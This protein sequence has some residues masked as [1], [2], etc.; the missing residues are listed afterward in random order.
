MTEL[1]AAQ[2]FAVSVLP[3]LFAITVH[4]VA[5]GWVA[6]QLGDQTAFQLG[7][8]TLN[9][10]KHIDPV[11][12]LLVPGIL[13]L[14]GGFIFGWAKPVP[15][16]TRNLRN[17]KR[18]MMLVAFAG[19]FAN[20]IMALMWAVV[21]KIGY[22]LTEDFSWVGVPLI[23]MA[24]MGIFINLLLFVLNLLPLPPLDGGRIL[25]GLLPAK[26]AV[27]YESIERYGLFIM[28]GLLISGILAKIILPPVSVI[29]QTL[30]NL[31]GL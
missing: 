4:E 31:F 26:V 8:L 6:K 17:P 28:I 18:D 23:Y 20:L 7:R 5:H 24:G 15:V 9:P 16:I 11:G 1:S 21:M 29:Q 12:T 27:K 14:M 30:Y 19:P 2:T 22:G 3:V 13:L 25:A 10:I